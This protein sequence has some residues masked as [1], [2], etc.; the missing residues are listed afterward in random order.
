[1]PI[2]PDD[3]IGSVQQEPVPG[4][5]FPHF[6]TE[7]SP[8]DAGYGLGAGIEQAGQDVQEAQQRSDSLAV[9]KMNTAAKALSAQLRF[10]P[11]NGAFTKQG[12][13]A[14]NLAPTYGPMFDDGIAKIAATAANPRQAAAFQQFAANEKV[15]FNLTL[16]RHEFEQGKVAENAIYETAMEQSV[17]SGS[18]DF[19]DS[20]A[21]Q[22]ERDTQKMLAS[23]YAKNH[24]LPQSVADTLAQESID[25]MN[26][27]VGMGLVQLDPMGSLKSLT[28]PKST[29]PNF[30]GITGAVREELIGRAKVGTARQ[31]SDGVVDTYRNFGPDAGAKAFAALDKQDLP[32]DAKDQA[33]SDIERGISQW[34]GEAREKYS[35]QLSTLE[36]HL[37]DPQ[38]LTAADRASI[39]D[40]RN[41]GVF[42][43]L[44]AGEALGRYDR[45][46]RAQD[47][48]AVSIKWADEVID[49]RR[50][51]DPD[52]PETKRAINLSFGKRVEGI[53][54]LSNTW[55]NTA[56]DITKATGVAPKDFVGVIRGQL[57]SGDP[58]TAGNAAVAI[59]R[60][61]TEAPM[62][63]KYSIDERL[64]A[65]AK[66][67]SD[68][69]SAGVPAT[70]AVELG[71]A[72]DGVS[73]ADRTRLEEEWKKRSTTMFGRT[74]TIQLPHD[75]D[76]DSRFHTPFY[77]GDLKPP[78]EMQGDY[79][80]LVHDH[81]LTT[82]GNID[83]A[84]AMALDEVKG[85]WGGS[86]LMNIAGDKEIVKYAPEQLS[87]FS[88]EAI[89]DDMVARVKATD[90]TVD[91]S[92]LVLMQSPMTRL[93]NG[94]K[95]NIGVPDKFGLPKVL[96]D[97][98]GQPFEYDIHGANAAN[99]K[100][101]FD[102][103]AEDAIN[104]QNKAKAARD[105]ETDLWD[106]IDA[107]KNLPH[108]R[109]Y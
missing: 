86:K 55:T 105:S 107:E 17:I 88:S 95:W 62:A 66:V 23:E 47:A 71:R 57:T 96:T 24:G 67:M 30:Q 34:R 92:K 73:D 91:T 14:V 74:G 109:L 61:M 52:D 27:N 98:Q 90:P 76:Q 16:N 102:E 9:I 53:D 97:E 11:Q 35:K 38:S 103:Q 82:N 12:E 28:D 69:L 93:S 75:L 60:L 99:Q 48:D 1:M 26:R 39:W 37:T 45:A 58:S 79:E 6:S 78:P 50:H 42:N 3:Q 44:E 83:A 85:S 101:L 56:M 51:A 43:G 2:V 40:L 89:K 41:K 22:K 84:K 19:R 68:A 36:D 100:R 46:Q 21:V 13:D 64:G 25:R 7:T 32:D 4:R 104:S 49:Q 54:P 77:K 108:N 106:S 15:D 80:I 18:N 20:V 5:A 29:D 65:K 8:A 72:L 70:Q 10:D 59:S 94:R 33:R 31:V 63:A 87:G 81:F